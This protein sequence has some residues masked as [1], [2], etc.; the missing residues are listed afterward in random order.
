M[1][2]VFCS[3]NNFA[4]QSKRKTISGPDV[5]EAV[6][7]M[8]FE[9]FAAPLKKSLEGYLVQTILAHKVRISNG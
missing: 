1:T 6:K 5:I 8:E 2:V 4:M 7:E 9:K 3:A